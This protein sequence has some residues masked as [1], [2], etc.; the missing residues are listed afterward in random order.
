M[1]FRLTLTPAKENTNGMKLL[2]GTWTGILGELASGV[3]R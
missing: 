2:N 3:N 1:S